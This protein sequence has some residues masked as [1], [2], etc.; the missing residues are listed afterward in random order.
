MSG[1]LRFG[2]DLEWVKDLD[3]KF[4]NNAK[5][6]F[7]KSITSYWPDLDPEKLQEDYVGIRPKIQKKSENMKDFVISG[8]K[9]H[10]LKGFI[11]LQGIESPGVTSSLAIAKFVGELVL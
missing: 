3:Y 2:P 4:E 11:N 10:N 8:P 1:Q 7:I 5:E 9:D 6:R